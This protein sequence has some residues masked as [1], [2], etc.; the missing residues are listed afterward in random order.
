MLHMP[1]Q[2]NI[3]A[4]GKMIRLIYGSVFLIAGIV[5]ML[6]WARHQSSIWPWILSI[7]VAVGGAFAIFESRA[8]WCVLRAM[9]FKTP[10]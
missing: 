6:A 5:L 4:R 8:G 10:I 2:C 7:A 9:G 3:D 1:F